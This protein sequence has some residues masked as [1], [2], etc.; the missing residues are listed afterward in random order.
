MSLKFVQNF[1]CKSTNNFFITLTLTH[2]TYAVF[3]YRTDTHVLH[4]DILPPVFFSV[5]DV[6]FFLLDKNIFFYQNA[7]GIK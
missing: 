5:S 7:P 4:N 3:M 6:L 1:L 2:S